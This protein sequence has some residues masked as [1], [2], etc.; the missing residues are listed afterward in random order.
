MS[1]P[2]SMTRLPDGYAA[3]I[4]GSGGIGRA[5]AEQLAD[6]P[7]CGYRATTAHRGQPAPSDRQLHLDITDEAS[8]RAAMGTVAEDVDAL[9]VLII[10][11]GVLHLGE[12][13]DV[14]PE[15]SMRE[16]DPDALA[17]AMRINAI[18]PLMVLRHAL[19][20]L[21][22]KQPSIA[23]ALSARVGSIGDNRMGGWYAYRGS[24]AALN[25]YWTTAAIETARRRKGPTCVLLH[26]GTVDTP[27]SQPFQANVADGKLFTPAYS[28][29]RL[30]TV[31]SGVT[32]DDNGRFYAWDGQAI[33]W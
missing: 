11:T 24:K 20:L 4:V 22:H 27:L 33:P 19:G 10:A 6:D 13:G 15:K 25:Q 2:V 26:P 31:L 9:H 3:M 21:Q 23:A 16:L 29:Q 12:A 17:T 8:I 7:R 28:A 18:G 5:L 32:D 1:D 30:L 14:A